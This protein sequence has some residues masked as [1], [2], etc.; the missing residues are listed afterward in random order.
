[1]TIGINVRAIISDQGPNFV[2]LSNLLKISP[3]K[4]YFELNG[5]KYFYIFDPPH[6]IKST[7]NNLYKHIIIFDNKEARWSH[8]ATF[9]EHDSKQYF[10]LAPK[11]TDIHITLPAFTNMSVKIAAQVLSHT[12]SA[13]LQTHASF[14][15]KTLPPEACHTAEFCKIMNDLFDSV[16]SYNLKDDNKF[17]CTITE[18]SCHMNYYK[19]MI[20]WFSNLRV[21][22][23]KSK[24]IT[25]QI[26]CIK[27][28]QITLSS[29]IHLWQYLH[30]SCQFTFLITRRL[31]QDPIENFFSII[32]QKGGKCDN[33]TPIMFCRIFRQVFTTQLINVSHSSKCEEDS[34]SFLILL[35]ETSNNINSLNDANLLKYTSEHNHI[36]HVSNIATNSAS[37]NTNID[38]LTD[39]PPFFMEVDDVHECSSEQ[40]NYC[41]SERNESMSEKTVAEQ[42]AMFYIAGYL[43]RKIFSTHQCNI[44]KIHLTSSSLDVV[45]DNQKYTTFKAYKNSDNNKYGS[46]YVASDSFFYYIEKCEKVVK[47]KFAICAH[48]TDISQT[49]INNFRPIKL[50]GVCNEFPME[51]LLKFFCRLRINYLI[52]FSNR[53]LKNCPKKDRKLSKLQS[54]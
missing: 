50:D 10:K 41:Y 2:Q 26:K 23:C 12:V 19:N 44:C 34:D 29:I 38:D 20:T 14:S 13:A 16:N 47:E 49:I 3:D 7:R 36:T 33:P 1:V 17:K 25:S 42:N 18:M 30:E 5:K 46:L 51:Y 22:N 39:L 53:S 6:L 11:L 54:F 9:Y 27:G 31:N 48:S 4:P 45:L 32:R 52:K 35:G 43:L 24:F 40:L 15:G 37:Q 8:I 28:W 21:K